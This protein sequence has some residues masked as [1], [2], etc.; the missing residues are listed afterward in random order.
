M[1]V[2]NLKPESIT[3]SRGWDLAL[4]GLGASVVILLLVWPSVQVA[5]GGDQYVFLARRL[6]EGRL[7]VD[8]LPPRYGDFALWQGHKY[9]P[10]GPLPAVLLVPLL[11]LLNA[12][13]ALVFVSYAFTAANVLI[14]YRVLGLTGV[15]D[16][17]RLWATLLYFAG[18]P[19]L[20]V[21]LIGISTYYAHIVATTFLLVAIHEAL[22]KRRWLLVGVCLGLAGACRFTEIFALPFF[23]WMA[24]VVD[25]GVGGGA[26]SKADGFETHPARLLPRLA[27]LFSGLAVPILLLCAY[28]YARFGNIAETGFGKAVLYRDVLY[29]ARSAGLFSLAHVPKNVFMMLLQGPQPVGGDSTAVLRFPYVEPSQWGMGL[30]FTSPALLYVFRARFSETLVKA[31]WIATL[32]LLVPI[33]AYYG[34]GYLQFGYRYALDFMPFLIVLVARGLPDPMTNRARALVTASVL[35][36]FWGALML[37]VWM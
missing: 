14:L 31:C 21:T 24:A 36:N 28:N 30:F 5:L 4:V 33:L 12:G 22:G 25:R 10:F 37:A 26:Q 2:V 11:P 16:E 7:D 19:Y 17:R 1:T 27:M 6:A 29:E 20:G 3:G 15:A 9:L 8:N 13:M 18:T 32:T 23:L 35:I 34:I